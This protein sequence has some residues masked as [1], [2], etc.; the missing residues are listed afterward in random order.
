M[1]SVGSLLPVPEVAKVQPP[2]RQIAEHYR[3]RIRALS[4]RPSDPMPSIPEIAK[5]WSVA[6]STAGRAIALLRDEGWIITAHGR[7]TYVSPDPPT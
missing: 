7:T 5:E 2:Y 4:L 1:T 6:T 3:A